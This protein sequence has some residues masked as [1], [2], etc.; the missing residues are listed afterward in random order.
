MTREYTENGHKYHVYLI[1]VVAVV[2]LYN[3]AVLSVDQ[4]LI[5]DWQRGSRSTIAG[6]WGVMF[7]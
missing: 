7:E 5:A 2:F 1:M 3:F 6:P 4:N